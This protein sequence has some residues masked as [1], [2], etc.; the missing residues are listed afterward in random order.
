MRDNT[1][2]LTV[3]KESC[4]RSYFASQ[5]SLASHADAR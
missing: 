4:Y 5:R 1:A 2:R 3:V